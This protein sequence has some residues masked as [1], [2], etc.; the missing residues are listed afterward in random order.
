MNELMNIFVLGLLYGFT[1]CSFSC[2]PYLAPYT[3]GNGNGFRDGIMGSVSFVSGKIFTYTFLG[4]AAAVLGGRAVTV[5]A[6]AA[7]CL[8]GAV[9]IITGSSLVF[10]KRKQSCSG[11]NT[12][13]GFLGKYPGRIPLF[14]AGV[15]TSIVPC[16]P[17]SALFIMA[18]NSGGGSTGALYGFLFGSGLM[19]SPI[20]L[21]GGV[22][23]FLSGRLR[24]ERPELRSFMTACSGV[25][26]IFMGGV[27][28]IK[29]LPAGY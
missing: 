18:S 11:S 26:L 6:K 25:I 17:L 24:A 23:G 9:L 5:D 2:M 12:V 21:A 7:G 8:F 28:L 4:G 13:T 14:T 19:I 10:K 1:T 29:A 3:F 27:E 16:L 22:L 20:V 15:M